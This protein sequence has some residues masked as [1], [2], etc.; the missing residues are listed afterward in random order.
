MNTVKIYQEN[1]NAYNNNSVH[2]GSSKYR[3]VDS[4]MITQIISSYGFEMSGVSASNKKVTSKHVMVYKYQGSDLGTEEVPTILVYN[5]HNRSCSLTFRLGFFRAVCANGL[6]VGDD[7]STPIRIRHTTSI[8]EQVI[9]AAI[10]QLM[11][12]VYDIAASVQKLKNTRIS[13]EDM[14]QY[15]KEAILLRKTN[16]KKI[17]IIKLVSATRKEDEENNL[18]NLM[19]IVQEKM[20]R[21][22]AGYKILRSEISKTEV[23]KGLWDIAERMAA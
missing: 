20:V 11:I 1:H 9:K 23:S 15:A 17:D 21:G 4:T 6:V 7:I 3:Q 22:G 19:N 10:G 5:S 14:I 8:N 13:Y 12:R 2:E 18:W 16:E